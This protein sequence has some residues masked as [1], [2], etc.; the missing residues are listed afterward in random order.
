MTNVAYTNT[1][2]IALDTAKSQLDIAWVEVDEDKY[3][4]VEARLSMVNDLLNK[5]EYA[6][7]KMAENNA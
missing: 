7:K 2:S 3:A 1:A 6:L 5:A 4:S